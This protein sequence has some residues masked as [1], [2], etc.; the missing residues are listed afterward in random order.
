MMMLMTTMMIMMIMMVMTMMI[1]IIVMIMTMMIFEPTRW[2]TAPP[3]GEVPT[4]EI[5]EREKS[6]FSIEC[7]ITSDLMLFI[8]WCSRL[9]VEAGTRGYSN[10]SDT[11][12]AY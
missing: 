7:E 4:L 10:Y 3:G 6:M 8:I 1:M 11:L 5:C 9:H 12:R 2:G